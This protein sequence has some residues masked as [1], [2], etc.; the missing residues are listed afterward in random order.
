MHIKRLTQFILEPIKKD[1]QTARIRFRIKW[2]NSKNILAFSL[3]FVV[4]VDKWNKDAQR[5][6]RNTTH[7]KDKVPAFEINRLLEFYETATFDIFTHYEKEQKTP[8]I[9]EVRNAINLR[10]KNKSPKD[11]SITLLDAVDIFITRQRLLESWTASTTRSNKSIIKT[12]KEFAPTA[13]LSDVDFNFFLKFLDFLNNKGYN[14]STIQKKLKQLKTILKRLNDAGY[15]TPQ[16]FTRFN[17]KIKSIDKKIIFLTK[18]EL[19]HIYNIDLDGSQSETRDIFCFCA[20]T[21]LRISDAFALQWTN[22]QDDCITIVTRKT[23]T[24]IVIELNNYAKEILKRQTKTKLNIFNIQTMPTYHNNIKQIAKACQIDTPITSEYYSGGQRVTE[25]RPKY[26]LIKSHTAR[27]TF[28]CL[29]LSMG[30]SPNVVMKWTGHKNYE[31][32]KPYIDITDEA[33]GKAMQLFNTL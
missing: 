28:I 20:F 24:P 32:M 19:L 5:C 33:K 31:S 25:T 10:V 13:R 3:P 9:D 2:L 11:D 8:T 26:E 14:N 7:G 21:G 22:I 29:A 16:D 12:I 17:P 15:K 27:R 6:T 4:D 18:D 30:I 1:P 23:S